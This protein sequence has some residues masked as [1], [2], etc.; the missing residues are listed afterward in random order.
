MKLVELAEHYNARRISNKHTAH[1]YRQFAKFFQN[2]S[3]PIDITAIDEEV[4]SRWK[5][6][7][8]ERV[9]NNTFN[10][11]LRHL[12]I[13]MN[14]GVSNGFVDANPFAD[15][16]YARNQ[17]KLPKTVDEKLIAEAI[18]RLREEEILSPGW[19]WAHLLRFMY[20]TGVRRHQVIAL[21]WKHLDFRNKTILLSVE[22]SKTGR[23]WLI[24]LLPAVEE[25]LLDIYRRTKRKQGICNLNQKVFNVTLFNERYQGPE[26][27]GSQLEGFFKRLSSKMGV[28]ISAHRLRH[29]I[30]TKLASGENPDVFAI[31]DL[32]GHTDIRTTRIYVQSSTQH[33]RKMLENQHILE[34]L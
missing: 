24:P 25:S 12:R 8:L 27:T 23:E 13:I 15:F 19:F 30:A 21:R 2:I 34:S 4:V 20:S 22:G 31:Q 14:H 28:R 9:C 17:R 11:Y 16:G 29:S 33:M 32:L 5:D 10:T 3:G 18:R 7:V 26:M 1:N 6:K